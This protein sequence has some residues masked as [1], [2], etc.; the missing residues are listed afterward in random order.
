MRSH[1]VI[2]RGD[3]AR[4]ATARFEPILLHRETF[5]YERLEE[6]ARH[7]R[8]DETVVGEEP[9]ACAQG[10]ELVETLAAKR[11]TE[12][13]LFHT[14]LHVRREIPEPVVDQHDKRQR[15]GTVGYPHAAG[16][17]LSRH[18]RRRVSARWRITRTFAAVRP[19]PRPTSTAESSAWNVRTS[20][21]RSRSLRPARNS[22][23]R[24]VS[25]RPGPMDSSPG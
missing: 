20:T 10:Q 23:S 16:S 19:R 4:D 2:V 1:K 25:T 24:A 7:H 18:A 3:A 22:A 17:A 21:L 13:V 5:R 8:A 12:H 11:A 15:L 9:H 6:R 14:L